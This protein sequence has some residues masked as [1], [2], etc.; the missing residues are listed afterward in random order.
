MSASAEINS[1]VREERW[2]SNPDRIITDQERS[3][4]EA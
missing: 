4:L 2:W 3:Q 1:G